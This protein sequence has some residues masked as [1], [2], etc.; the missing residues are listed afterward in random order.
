MTVKS[1]SFVY[2]TY[3]RTTPE[4]LFKAITA[5]EI[6]RRYWGHENVSDWTPGSKWEHV[7]ANDERPVEIVGTVVEIDP[8]RRLVL[9]WSAASKA[10]DPDEESRVVFEIEGLDTGMVKLVVTH[11]QLQPGSGMEKGISKGWPLV[12]SS[13]KSFIETGT[14]LDF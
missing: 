1:A 3:I 14:G 9:T 2:V 13:L 12:L 4:E 11:D 5:P 8:P 7:R 6:A 10:G